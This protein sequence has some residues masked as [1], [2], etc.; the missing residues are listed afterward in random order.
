MNMP[1][2]NAPHVEGTLAFNRE[3]SATKVSS[4]FYA[5]DVLSQVLASEQLGQAQTWGNTRKHQHSST[6]Y[7]LRKACDTRMEVLP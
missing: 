6:A 4:R 1:A 3:S 7:P 5:C 2:L